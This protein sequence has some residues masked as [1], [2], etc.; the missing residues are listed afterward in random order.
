[1]FRLKRKSPALRP[2]DITPDFHQFTI[3]CCFARHFTRR[4]VQVV[5][6]RNTPAHSQQQTRLR[7]LPE[8]HQTKTVRHRTDAEQTSEKYPFEG[9]SRAKVLTAVLLLLAEVAKPRKMSKSGLNTSFGRSPCMWVAQMVQRKKETVPYF[10]L[11]QPGRVNTITQP[12]VFCIEK[13]ARKRANAQEYESTSKDVF[14]NAGV[15]IGRYTACIRCRQTN[16]RAG[17]KRL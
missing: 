14:C 8:E 13:W 15:T 16:F 2:S 4:Y 17:E 7:L 10:L 3:I 9:I 12:C 1:M 5:C 11:I 6:S